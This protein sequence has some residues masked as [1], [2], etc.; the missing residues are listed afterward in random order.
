L[1]RSTDRTIADI[2]LMAGF[3]VVIGQLTDADT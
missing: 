2:C 1:L 3:Q